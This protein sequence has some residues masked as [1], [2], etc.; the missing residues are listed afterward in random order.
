[1]KK[2]FLP[3]LLIIL[4]T[5][6]SAVFDG[7][8]DGSIL[9][10]EDGTPISNARVAIYFDEKSR[11][12]DFNEYKNQ[13]NIDFLPHQTKYYTDTNVNGVYSFPITWETNNPEFGKDADEKPIYLLI[14]HDDYGL[15][16][17]SDTY[18]IRSDKSTHLPDQRL[19]K[20]TDT[21]TVSID[22]RDYATDSSI[23]TPI[24]F[25]YK[26]T[27]IEGE[28]TGTLS[29]TN[30]SFVIKYNKDL[31]TLSP[32]I[33]ELSNIRSLSYKQDKN[34][35]SIP[36]YSLKDNDGK[37]ISFNINLPISNENIVV[38]MVANWFEFTVG[39]SGEI[40]S[41]STEGELNGIAIEFKDESGQVVD[42]V[43]T[44]S[45]FT[46]YEEYKGRF[47]NLAAGKVFFGQ[48]DDNGVISI[49]GTVTQ[50]GKETGE[51]VILTNTSKPPFISLST[52]E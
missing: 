38:N 6:C 32:V 31:N 28:H 17:G 40:T 42:T 10:D 51:S 3:I 12:A 37:S 46:Q 4:L 41:T 44:E 22:F 52:S 19:E 13:S 25:T 50:K 49:N 9:D 16:K 15:I 27:D 11:D 34:G 2:L 30:S 47:S 18:Y 23:S 7:S 20:I 35:D 33:I 29:N 26:Y 43:Y 21:C 1:M 14:Y 39:I 45:V 48:A 24:E 36:Q 5:S 8:I